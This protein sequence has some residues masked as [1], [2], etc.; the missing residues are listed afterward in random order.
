VRTLRLQDFELGLDNAR[1]VVLIHPCKGVVA[2]CCAQINQRAVGA[3]V[4][5]GVRFGRINVANART[6]ANKALDAVRR[7]KRIAEDLLGLLADAVN[8]ASALNQ[9]DNRPRQV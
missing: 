6:Q 5:R 8:T 2:L 1:V 7:Q 3:P 4:L 9:T